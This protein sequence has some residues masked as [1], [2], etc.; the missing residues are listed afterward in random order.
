MYTSPVYIV[1]NQCKLRQMA[2][3]QGIKKVISHKFTQLSWNTFKVI[4]IFRGVKRLLCGIE[5]VDKYVIDNSD[6]L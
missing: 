6:A 1:E 2:P 5:D 4:F 3:I